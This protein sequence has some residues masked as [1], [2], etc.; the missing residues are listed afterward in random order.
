[1]S[2]TILPANSIYTLPHFINMGNELNL[3]STN[4]NLCR[5]AL[6]NSLV[7][8][9]KDLNSPTQ[10]FLSSEKDSRNIPNL[11]FLDV[12][13]N[14]TTH[15]RMVEST[16]TQVSPSGPFLVDYKISNSGQL[17][18]D[19]L[20]LF[21]NLSLTTPN[22]TPPITATSFYHSSLDYDRILRN[23]G[24]EASELLSG[25]EDVSPEYMFQTY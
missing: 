24:R 16:Y 23:S 3:G 19:L 4:Y 14:L 11:N 25:K 12:A 10:Q 9:Y 17:S 21:L 2:G 20:S 13:N 5:E 6:N 22:S 15:T 8:K 18:P 1:M 7:Y